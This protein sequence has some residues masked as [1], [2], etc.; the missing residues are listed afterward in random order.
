MPLIKW[1]DSY[2]VG[3]EQFD[4]EHL[5]LVE[6]INRMF[7]IVRDRDD[8]S[9]VSDAVGRLIDYTQFH[10]KSEEAALQQAGFPNL[11]AH[12]KQHAELER[13]VLAF[14]QLILSENE[15]VRVE[16]YSFLREWLIKHILEEDKQY[17]KFLTDTVPA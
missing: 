17:T 2:S 14:Q 1:R 16:F 5:K 6:L 9:A 8:V 11:G 4:N 10:F 7:V 3:V 15:S 12:K 13:Q